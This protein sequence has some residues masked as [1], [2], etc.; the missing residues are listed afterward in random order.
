MLQTRSVMSAIVLLTRIR[1]S[2]EFHFGHE[3]AMLQ[4]SGQ[5]CEQSVSCVRAGRRRCWR[6]VY[7]LERALSRPEKAKDADVDPLAL[8][9]FSRGSASLERGARES[10]NSLIWPGTFAAD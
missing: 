8:K 2:Q 7:V 1:E 4:Y 5:P 3:R 10:P 6:V 9:L